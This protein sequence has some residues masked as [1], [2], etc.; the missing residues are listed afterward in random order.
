MPALTLSAATSRITRPKIWN[1][2]SVP[3]S[4][5]GK[6]H[7]AIYPPGLSTLEVAGQVG[8]DAAGHVP[9]NI[10][11]QSR[12][13]WDNLQNVLSSN[14]MSYCD[15]V[16]LRVYLVSRDDLQ[17]FRETKPDF[18]AEPPRPQSVLFVAGLLDPRW[19][20][21]I[22]ARAVKVPYRLGRWNDR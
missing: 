16:M 18:A 22:E 12:L 9:D 1:P 2:A 8:V 4:V 15:I 19:K 10:R 21:E 13:A 11:D 17:G 6:S 14:S 5:D 7:C 20:I 3:Q